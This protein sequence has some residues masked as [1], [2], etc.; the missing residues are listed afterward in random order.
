VGQHFL[1]KLIA[2]YA[3]VKVPPGEDVDSRTYVETVV[4][5]WWYSA[6]TPGSRRIFAFLT[7]ADLLPQQKWRH[8]EWFRQCLGETRHLGRLLPVK[9]EFTHVPKS[10]TAY[11][12]WLE[13]CYRDGWLAVGD[14]AQSYDPISG[15][16]LFHAL[17]TGHEAALCLRK[18]LSGAK[19]GLAKYAALNRSLWNRFLLNR[20]ECY[21]SATRWHDQPFWQRRVDDGK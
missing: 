21:A 4:N 9:V 6:L 10:T 11:S 17:L 12:A 1:D 16:G 7:D 2:I 19:D 3:L 20:Q 5:G 13:S 18:E 8:P 15:E 14:A